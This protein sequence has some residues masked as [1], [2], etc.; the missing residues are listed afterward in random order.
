MVYAEAV[1]KVFAGIM[2]VFSI[3]MLALQ[4]GVADSPKIPAVI[5]WALVLALCVYV[6]FFRKPEQKKPE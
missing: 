3:A 6:L 2:G 4:L 1:S 5:L